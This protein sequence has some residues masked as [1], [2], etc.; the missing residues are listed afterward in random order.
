VKGTVEALD[1]GNITK[2]GV[3]V[4]VALVV[5]GVL[6]SLVISALIARVIILVVVVGLAVLVW[7][8]RTH[9]KDQVDKCQLNATFFGIHVSAPQSVVNECNKKHPH[10]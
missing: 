5:V 9:I 4:I 7:Q 1:T 8:Q 2:I 10:A 3:I 6:L